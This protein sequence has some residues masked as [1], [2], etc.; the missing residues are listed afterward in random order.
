MCIRDRIYGNMLKD[1]CDG[2]IVEAKERAAR[3]RR[4]K[5]ER[6]AHESRIKEIEQSN[7]KHSSTLDIRRADKRLKLDVERVVREEQASRVKINLEA[8][9]VSQTIQA[10]LKSLARMA[11]VLQTVA[12]EERRKRVSIKSSEKH[13]RASLL[14]FIQS[15]TR[16]QIRLP[17]PPLPPPPIKFEAARRMYT[18]FSA[19]N[20]Q[21]R[22]AK[23]SAPESKSSRLPQLASRYTIASR[24]PSGPTSPRHQIPDDSSVN[25][26]ESSRGVSPN[27]LLEV[28]SEG[29]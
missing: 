3:S 9:D 2:D 6:L 21:G 24:T 13:G 4:D 27:L 19:S 25:M 14:A 5:G 1:E 11:G 8:L 7:D 17:A 15:R 22:S 29:M 28:E 23:F 16:P 18:A 12:D 20:T 26:S 10:Q